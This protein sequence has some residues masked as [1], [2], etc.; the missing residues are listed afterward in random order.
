MGIEDQ[1]EDHALA[2]PDGASQEDVSEWLRVNSPEEVLPPEM[3]VASDLDESEK[4]QSTHTIQLVAIQP[5]TYPVDTEDMDHVVAL[6]ERQSRRRSPEHLEKAR[7]RQE[8][9]LQK[10]REKKKRRIIY[11][12]LRVFLKLLLSLILIVG[13]YLFVTL[14]YWNFSADRFMLH[15]AHLLTRQHIARFLQTLDQKPIYRINPSALEQTIRREI[16]LVENVFIRRHLFPVGLD[17]TVIEKPSW[18]ILYAKPPVNTENLPYIIPK[19][20]VRLTEDPPKPPEPMYLLHW[21][22]TVTDLANYRLTKDVLQAIGS[23]VPLVSSS[24]IKMDNVNLKR[25]RE[26]S[27]LLNSY[28]RE[29]K[30]LFL[31]VS[32]PYDIYAY[33]DRFRVRLGRADSS[34]ITRATRLFSLI[35]AIH[36]HQDQIQFVDLRWAQQIIF[37]KKSPAQV[38]LAKQRALL[39]AKQ[40]AEVKKRLEGQ[41]KQDTETSSPPS[42]LPSV[43]E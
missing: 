7:R 23:P 37:K 25:Y 8:V 33:Y 12:R 19:Q 28:P 15:G 3:P 9:F 1:H 39:K 2:P 18:G 35:P 43:R 34:V 24:S 30:L 17:V 13:L 4:P 16:P 38:A 11:N 6:Q 22:N 42:S 40:A 21:D 14:R 31:D 27:Q 5:E 29:A 41:A 10:R 36:D 26:L 20:S 32:N